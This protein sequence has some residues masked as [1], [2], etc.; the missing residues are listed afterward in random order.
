VRDSR[1]ELAGIIGVQGPASRFD[2]RAMRAAV[3]AL[4]NHTE[5]LSAALGW[6]ET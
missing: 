3:P 6:Q 4:V 2:A 1:G 5:A